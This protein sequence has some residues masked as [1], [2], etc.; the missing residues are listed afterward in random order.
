MPAPS[1]RLT[2]CLNQDANHDPVSVNQGQP[3][4]WVGVSFPGTLNYVLSPHHIP[5][6]TERTL[7]VPEPFCSPCQHS[8]P[9]RAAADVHNT[10][11]ALILGSPQRLI[12]LIWGS[13]WPLAVTNVKVAA[14]TEMDAGELSAW[15]VWINKI[16]ESSSHKI[17]GNKT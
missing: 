3:L 15:W 1:L 7:A 16:M 14:A 4:W 13:P 11:C 12:Y 6:G 5:S 2:C 8:V 17:K 9:V 10:R